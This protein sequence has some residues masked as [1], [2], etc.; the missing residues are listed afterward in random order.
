M[1][2]KILAITLCVAMLAIAIVGGTLAYFTDNDTVVNTFTAGNVEIDLTEGK[3]LSVTKANIAD[4]AGRRLGDLVFVDQANERN[5]VLAD[6]ETE[7]FYGKVYPAQVID[8]D[9]TITNLGS[10]NAFVAAKITVTDGVGNLANVMNTG[11]MDLLNI[12]TMVRGGLVQA[13]AA[14]LGDYFTLTST[15]YPVYGDDTYAIYQTHPDADTWVFYIFMEEA[16]ATNESVVLFEQVFVPELWDNAEMVELKEM[17]IDIK[18]YAVQEFGF[19]DCFTAMTTAFAND[20][21]F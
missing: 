3:T 14:Q 21:A 18:A 7:Y 6:E 20:F 17:A 8:K 16:L 1:K 9:P 4:Y 15:A 5:D 13:N 19:A 2:K 12:Q 11:Y 10:E